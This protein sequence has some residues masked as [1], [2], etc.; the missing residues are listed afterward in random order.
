MTAALS[1]TRTLVRPGAYTV[2]HCKDVV[3]LVWKERA[4]VGAVRDASAFGDQLMRGHAVFSVVHVVEE[5]SGLP[6]SAGRDALVEAAQRNEGRI[7]CV[8]LLLPASPIVA[9]MLRVSVRAMDKFVRSFTQVVVEPTID[10]L[11]GGVLKANVQRGGVR[12]TAGELAR[13]I[14]EARAL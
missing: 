12:L 13:A 8:G 5:T 6:T 9:S 11:V 7:A 3:I 4:D 2:A 10:A 14:Q 1:L